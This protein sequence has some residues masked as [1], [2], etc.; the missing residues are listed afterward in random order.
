M[1]VYNVAYKPENKSLS[2]T[3]SDS[4]Q[5]SARIFQNWSSYIDVYRARA[6]KRWLKFSGHT[7]CSTCSLKQVLNCFLSSFIFSITVL[8][9]NIIPLRRDYFQSTVLFTTKLSTNTKF[10][11]LSSPHQTILLSTSS[12][13]S[14]GICYN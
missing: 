6:F 11:F 5:I 14:G 7:H 12:H 1:N 10:P 8:C 4:F 9:N 13:Q 2:Y 3:N